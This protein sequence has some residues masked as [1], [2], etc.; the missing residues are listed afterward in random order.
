MIPD[1]LRRELSEHCDH[2]ASRKVGLIFVMQKIQE[3]YGGWLNDDAIREAAEIVGVSL[4]EV[5]EVATF[6]NWFFREPVGRTVIVCCDSIACHLCGCDRN[7]AHL[8]R[9]LGI[10][11]GQTT[12]DGE[13][14]LLPIVCLGNCDNAPT[15]MI[16]PE[17]YDRMTPEKIDEVLDARER[18][19]TEVR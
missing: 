14:T 1:H 17:L 10:Q 4:P 11:T 13:Y 19:A 9:R 12:R 3:Y 18:R 6:Y 16:G 8:E 2:Y 15:M 5:E 7:L